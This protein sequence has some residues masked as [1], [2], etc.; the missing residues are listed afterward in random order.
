MGEG[1]GEA[2]GIGE[3]DG[4]E[5]RKVVGLKGGDR[6]DEARA[7]G[8]AV[9][10][11]EADAEADWKR[12]RDDCSEAD[13]RADGEPL[14]DG[15]NVENR[16]ATGLREGTREGVA[17]GEV[18]LNGDPL[19]EGASPVAVAKAVG[20][21]VPVV[22][23]LVVVGEGMA[24]ALLVASTS[25]PL[26]VCEELRELEAVGGAVPMAV[27]AVV[28]VRGALAVRHE[29][30]ADWVKALAVPH[31]DGVDEVPVDCEGKPLL[32]NTAVCVGGGGGR[33]P[34]TD[35]VPHALVVRETVP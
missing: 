8:V 6:E 7:E 14:L 32:L 4:E 2:E 29:G 13:C 19:E 9:G 23:A 30:D 5:E 24:A 18:D 34:L 12:E 21:A 11:G 22:K 16:D 15:C 35:T 26:G 28:G 1:G 17:E 10:S 25:V 33:V 20:G 3:P 27:A 31:T